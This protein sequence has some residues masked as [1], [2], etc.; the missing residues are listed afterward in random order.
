LAC[1]IPIKIL[2][3]FRGDKMEINR[4]GSIN[5]GNSTGFNTNPAVKAEPVKVEQK[6]FKEDTAKKEFKVNR[7]ELDSSVSKANK[8]FFKNNTHLQ[9]KIHEETHDV[10]VKII[11]DASGE[12]VKEIPPEKFVEM[13]AK[14]CEVAGVFV[15]EKR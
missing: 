11:D 5:N 14:I 13:M 10:I 4:V 3:K 2:E 8:I 7:K 6:D 9:F 15:D 12:V 1:F